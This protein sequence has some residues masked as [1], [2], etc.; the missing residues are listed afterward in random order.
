MKKKRNPGVYEFKKTKTKI[1]RRAAEIV[2][3]SV[4]SGFNNHN[5]TAKGIFFPFDS[6][7]QLVQL[8]L[9]KY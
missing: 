4:L 6:V 9:K 5:I 1:Q 7:F 2:K 3:P 8:K